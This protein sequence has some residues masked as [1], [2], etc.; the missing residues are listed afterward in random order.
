MKHQTKHTCKQQSSS[1]CLTHSQHIRRIHSLA[2]PVKRGSTG[3][4]GLRNSQGRHWDAWLVKMFP[5]VVNWFFSKQHQHNVTISFS[6]FSFCQVIGQSLPSSTALALFGHISKLFWMEHQTCGQ[7]TSTPPHHSCPNHCTA[8]AREWIPL[9]V[10]TLLR[11][12]S[13]E[14]EYENGCWLF[15]TSQFTV[16]LTPALGWI[17]TRA[18]H[19]QI[20]LIVISVLQNPMG[21]NLRLSKVHV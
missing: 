1:S 18:M 10:K 21:L 16:K 13:L 8:V 14:F 4:I 9:L 11:N 20:G 2:W 17:V 5:N 15:L 6:L 12:T 19:T 7:L 3:I